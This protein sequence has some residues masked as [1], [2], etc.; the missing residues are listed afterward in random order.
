MTNEDFICPITNLIFFDPVLASDGRYYEKKAITKWLKD[1]STSPVTRQ[2]IS[3]TLYPCMYFKNRLQDFLNENPDKLEEQYIVIE[4]YVE[5]KAHVNSLITTKNFNEL[6]VYVDYHFESMGSNM[7]KSLFTNCEDTDV[8]KHII[9]NCID[10]EYKDGDHRR[11]IHYI[12]INKSIELI[13]IMM[14]KKVELNCKDKFGKIPLEYI[15]TDDTDEKIVVEFIKQIP[16]LKNNISMIKI[17]VVFACK[18]NKLNLL[19]YIVDMLPNFNFE[20]CDDIGVRPVHYACQHSSLDMIKFLDEKGVDFH[21]KTV[22][23]ES[24]I[25]YACKSSD[26]EKIKYLLEQKRV[27]LMCVDNDGESAFGY[28]FNEI[29]YDVLY[30]LIDKGYDIISDYGIYMILEDR[31]WD[32]IRYMVEKYNLATHVD[33]NDG[34]P[35]LLY[36]CR[37]FDG[38]CSNESD[39]EQIIKVSELLEFMIDKGAPLECHDHENNTPLHLICSFGT[40]KLIKY[41]VERGGDLQC[42]NDEGYSPLYYLLEDNS[43]EICNDV[44]RYLI[45]KGHN[46]NQVVMCDTYVIHKL[47]EKKKLDSVKYMIEKGCSV[48]FAGENGDP[49]ILHVCRMFDTVEELEDLEDLEDPEDSEDLD[50]INK[51]SK[52]LKFMINKG[53]NLECYSANKWTPLHYICKYGTP[54][55]VKYAVSKASNLEC[56]NNYNSTPLHYICRFTCDEYPNE[57]LDILK[58]MIQKGAN[59]NS[60]TQ[61]KWTPCHYLCYSSS[62]ENIKYVITNKNIDINLDCITKNKKSLTDMLKDNKKL[63]EEEKDV[64]SM[65]VQITNIKKKYKDDK[66]KEIIS[67]L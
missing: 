45:D 2:P 65:L 4:T 20:Y 7:F 18:Y 52:L 56:Q 5:N 15:L 48:N 43:A 32:F 60:Q 11:I 29:N 57:S 36:V 39:P 54:K 51:I 66:Y 30:Y 6:K 3:K 27:D 8:L 21:S 17:L 19:K 61:K 44:F 28:I 13:S 41:V 31:N 62:Y 25:H 38:E 34:E 24:V 58:L 46:V 49:L 50:E 16:D 1:H 64:L 63:G 47:I 23:G 14:K 22:D 42:L 59:F 55:L 33:D 9:T 37:L 67:L 10:Y 26:L 53:A 40:S 12:C 35:L